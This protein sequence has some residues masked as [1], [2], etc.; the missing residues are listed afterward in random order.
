MTPTSLGL[1]HKNYLLKRISP[2]NTKIKNK[3]DLVISLL[4]SL[5]W[6]LATYKIKFKFLSRHTRPFI[7]QFQP[8]FPDSV[9]TTLSHASAC[10]P[11]C[12]LPLGLPE[13][14]LYL[15]WLMKFYLNFNTHLHCHFLHKAFL[16]LPN[17][18]PISSGEKEVPSFSVFS[19]TPSHCYCLYVLFYLPC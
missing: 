12:Y 6:F 9:S 13:S 11:A 8:T 5:W 17:V 2:N 18:P 4:Q 10:T 19:Q 14:A 15:L 16:V 7:I 3:K 1:T